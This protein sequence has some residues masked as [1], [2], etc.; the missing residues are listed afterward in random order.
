MAKIS[1]DWIKY[2]GQEFQKPY[3]LNLRKK[4]IEEYKTQKIYPKAHDIFNAFHYT[5]FEDTKVVIL[6]Q[7]PYH[8][9]NQAHGLSFSVQKGIKAPP[10]LVNIFKEL[11]DEYGYKIPN[12]GYL[13]SWADQGVLLLNTS[14]TVREKSPTS[15]KDIGWQTFTD[16]VIKALNKKDQTVVYLLWGSHARSKK[17]LINN[18][19]A[20]ILESVHPSPLSAYRGFFGCGHFKKTNEILL[21]E[22]LEEIDWEIKDI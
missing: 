6:G 9:P 8:G 11:K 20:Y 13:K 15:H 2:I 19:K 21:K 18:K 1:N 16:Q 12:N 7:D 17:K 3:Y 4:L 14:L 5:S 10:S 22:N